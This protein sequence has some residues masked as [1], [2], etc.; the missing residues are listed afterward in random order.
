MEVRPINQE[1]ACQQVLLEDS[2]V[3]S[4]QWSIFPV[5]IACG[6]TPSHLL[7]RYFSYIRRATLS[8]IRPVVLSTGVD[9]YLL[10]SRWSLISFLPPAVEDRSVVLRIC[11]G[12]LVQPHQC[13]RGEL[14]FSIEP[15]PDGAKVALQLSD[16]CPLLLGGSSPSPVRRWLYRL[17]QAAIHRLVTIRFLMLLYRD[18]AGVSAPVQVVNVNVR[19]G[20]PV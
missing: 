5:E 9:L 18:L 11:G 6:L 4:V 1:I 19:D 20:R 16:Y 17:T 7:E 3:F 2:S 8:T 10:G 15:T 13:H 14:R 12:L